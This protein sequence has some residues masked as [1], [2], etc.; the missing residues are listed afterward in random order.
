MARVIALL[1]LASVVVSAQAETAKNDRG[2]ASEE[3]SRAAVSVRG[4]DDKTHLGSIKCV[5]SSEILKTLAENGPRLD[6][7]R[8]Y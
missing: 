5:L 3:R 6:D 1:V 4:R 8:K 7:T 2:E